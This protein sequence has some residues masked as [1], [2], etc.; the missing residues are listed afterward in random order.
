MYPI[1]SR[2][3]RI[4]FFLIAIHFRACMHYSVEFIGKKWW[5]NKENT[6]HACIHITSRTLWFFQLKFACLSET[7]DMSIIRGEQGQDGWSW[8]RRIHYP[9]AFIAQVTE[10]ATFFT[11]LIDW[12]CFIWAFLLFSNRPS[13]FFTQNS[14]HNRSDSDF[15]DPSKSRKLV[16]QPEAN[17]EY[18]IIRLFEI[19]N[20]RTTLLLRYR[21]QPIAQNVTCARCH[22]QIQNE[23]RISR[24]KYVALLISYASPH[25]KLRLLILECAVGFIAGQWQDVHC[26]R[27]CRMGILFSFLSDQK[28]PARWDGTFLL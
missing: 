5:R 13:L 1:Y 3:G 11:F 17:I 7:N 6:K 27:H 18:R 26:N 14:N 19:P 25:A 24:T 12:F 4:F 20:I 8:T 10:E 28:R 2:D 22:V 15:G 16:T 21:L 9:R 23:E